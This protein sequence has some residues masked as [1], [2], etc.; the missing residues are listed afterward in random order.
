MIKLVWVLP[1]LAVLALVAFSGCGNGSAATPSH[2]DEKKSASADN[3]DTKKKGSH[4]SGGHTHVAPHGGLVN[5][6]GNY[7]VELVHEMAT[8]KL[9]FYI[10][11]E[12]GTSPSPVDAKPI[13]GQFKTEGVSDFTPFTLNP[14]PQAGEN[15]GMA[16]RFEA[17]VSGLEKG[18][19][20]EL[21][22]RPTI[23]DKSYRTAYQLTPGKAAAVAKFYACP[24]FKEHPKLYPQP[25]QCDICKMVLAELKD[26]KMEHSDHSPKHGG[27]F[28][29]ASDNWHHMEGVLASAT[30]FRIYLYD[31]FTKP[32]SAKGYEGTAS[33]VRQD[34]KGDDL[35][36][37]LKLNLQPNA[38]GSFLTVA[39]PPEYVAPLDFRVY[40]TLQKG[41]KPSLFNFTFDNPSFK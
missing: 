16:S 12:D 35:G 29:M 22:V 6:I 31:N 25:G 27:T 34:S 17:A 30:E 20:Y 18:K 5:S 38:D 32:I 39:I 33:V 3:S 15:E 36:Q 1:V 8:S 2:E 28:F 9:V 21:F 13:L 37:T 26:G 24:M 40:I 10:L 4:E 7:H 14:A 41:E 23:E 11:G 19:S